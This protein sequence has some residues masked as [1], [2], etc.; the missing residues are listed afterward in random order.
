MKVKDIRGNE[1]DFDT[2]VIYMDSE[3]REELHSKISPCTEQEFYNAYA[4]A[5]EEKF[6]ERFDL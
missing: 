5:H 6:G 1:I 2:A 4:R 3:I